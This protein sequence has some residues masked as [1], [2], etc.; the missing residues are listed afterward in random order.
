MYF[1][2]TVNRGVAEV[3]VGIHPTCGLPL[4]HSM[5]K[6]ESGFDFLLQTSVQYS[7]AT[8]TMGRSVIE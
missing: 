1:H 8:S 7:W 6:T 4:S 5:S 3:S 2:I